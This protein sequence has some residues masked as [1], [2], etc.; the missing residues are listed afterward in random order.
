MTLPGRPGP[1]HAGR[2]SHARTSHRMHAW[3]WL[4]YMLRDRPWPGVRV[5]ENKLSAGGA[6]QD[7]GLDPKNKNRGSPM[8]LPKAPRRPGLTSLFTSLFTSFSTLTGTQRVDSSGHV[9]RGSLVTGLAKVEV[10]TH[11][12]QPFCGCFRVGLGLPTLGLGVENPVARRC[13]EDES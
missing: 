5:A 6:P 11:P 13:L 1:A 7:N 4:L 12:L 8:T 9:G 10:E 3:P 2:T